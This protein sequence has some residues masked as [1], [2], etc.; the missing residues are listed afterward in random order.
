MGRAKRIEFRA[1]GIALTNLQAKALLGDEG[2]TLFTMLRMT[3]EAE[4][5]LAGHPKLA[6]ALDAW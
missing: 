3:P 1:D 4:Q 2:K 5:W 6:E